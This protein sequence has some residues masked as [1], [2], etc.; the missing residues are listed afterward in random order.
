MLIFDCDELIERKHYMNCIL[1]LTQA[2]EIFF[3]LFL[4]V[5]LLYKPFWAD[6]NW[7]LADLNKLADELRGKIENHVFHSMRRLFLQ[8]L[9]NGRSPKDL[10]EA[11]LFVAALLSN[12]PKNPDDADID[13]LGDAELASLLKALRATTIHKLKNRIVHKEAYRPTRNEAMST[14]EETKN[15]LLPLTGH[16]K[17]RD[18]DINS[19]MS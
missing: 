19:Y 6:A 5:E 13:K 8:H 2:Y 14:I 16:L 15:I 18:D 12:N 7:E 9:V 17:L 3:N 4:R 11:K 1:S 10:A